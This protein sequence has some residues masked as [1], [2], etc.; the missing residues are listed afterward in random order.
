MVLRELPVHL[1]SCSA[2]LLKRENI[3][4]GGLNAVL[5]Y[6]GEYNGEIDKFKLPRTDKVPHAGIFLQRNLSSTGDPEDGLM[7][8]VGGAHMV[9]GHAEGMNI[10]LYGEGQVLGVD[11]GRGSYQQDIHENYSRIFAAH[12]TVIVNGNSRGDSG[13]STMESIQ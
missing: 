9:H 3:K 7:C 4:E 1:G 10:E 5:W 11:N 12:N 2:G 13:G 8:F 6:G